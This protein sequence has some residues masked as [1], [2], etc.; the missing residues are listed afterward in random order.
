MSTNAAALPVNSNILLGTIKSVVTPGTILLRLRVETR[1]EHVALEDALDLMSTA[2]TLQDYQH[3]L[4]MFYHFY[5]PLEALLN[6]NGNV[7]VTRGRINKF[8]LLRNDMHYLGCQMDAIAWCTKL[9]PL[10]TPADVLGCLYVLEGATLGGRLISK[11][12]QATLGI[13]PTSGGSFF[14]GYGDE[15]AAMW[16]GMRQLLLTGA[17]DSET[18]NAMVANAI[19]TFKCLRHWYQSIEQRV[20]N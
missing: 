2:L 10:S 19:S 13:L 16:Q 11:H 17:V 15:T 7:E 20:I 14:Q 3:R 18:E 8:E 1:T 4:R 9:P 5:T 6:V 12:I